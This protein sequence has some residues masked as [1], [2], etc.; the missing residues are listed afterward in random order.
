MNS[1]AT[2]KSTISKNKSTRKQKIDLNSIIEFFDPIKKKKGLSKKKYKGK[3]KEKGSTQKHAP[4]NKKVPTDSS[5]SDDHGIITW[6]G[7]VQKQ[8]G[9][10]NRFHLRW[11]MMRGLT[12]YWY[13]SPIDIQQ[14]GSI[15]IPNV[16]IHHNKVGSNVSHLF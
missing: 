13:R 16:L 5:T 12:L 11:M 9:R 4:L 14:K 3:I 2:H 8:R 7:N 15:L 6:Y 1:R 10:F